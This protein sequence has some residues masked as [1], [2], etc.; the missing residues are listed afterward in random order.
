LRLEAWF[1]N[2]REAENA[3]NSLVQEFGGYEFELTEELSRDWM[4]TWRESMKPVLLTEGIWVS[5]KWLPPSADN[6][7]NW[8][9]IEPRMAFGTGHH[10]TTRLAAKALCRRIKQAGPDCRLLDIGCGSGILCFA[11]DACGASKCVGI[12]IDADCLQNIAENRRLNDSNNTICFAIGTCEALNSRANFELAVMNII[13]NHA[14]PLLREAVRMLLPKGI[15]VW[16]GL[17]LE[18]RDEAVERAR[19][20]GLTLLGESREG[21][22]WCGEFVKA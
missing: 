22:W 13:R 14:E 16:S 1:E 12:E 21:E 10:E 5:P 9:K 2:I 19:D 3:V 11:A 4:R 6:I 17:L 20:E 18:Q 15:I 7:E 8:I